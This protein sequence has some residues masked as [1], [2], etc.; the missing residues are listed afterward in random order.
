MKSNIKNIAKVVDSFDEAI[1]AAKEMGNDIFAGFTNNIPQQKR[2]NSEMGVEQY[3]VMTDGDVYYVVESRGQKILN[4][5]SLGSSL[6]SAPLCLAFQ[7]DEGFVFSLEALVDKSDQKARRE[8][9]EAGFILADPGLA[10]PRRV[11][12]YS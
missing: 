1:E 2:I 9:C 3:F 5:I 11:Y 7:N 6:T 8:S 4:K 10:A 12:D